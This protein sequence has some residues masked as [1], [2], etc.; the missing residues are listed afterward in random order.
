M[1]VFVLPTPMQSFF[2]ELL[3]TLMVPPPFPGK[4]IDSTSIKAT[5]KITANTID[6]IS[7]DCKTF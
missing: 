2:P 7:H 6:F 3:H 5:S 1:Q 4:Q